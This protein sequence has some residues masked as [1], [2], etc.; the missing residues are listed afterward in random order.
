MD[1]LNNFPYSNVFFMTWPKIKFQTFQDYLWTLWWSLWSHF[2]FLLFESNITYIRK[3]MKYKIQLSLWTN[4][5]HNIT[6]EGKKDRQHMQIHVNATTGI[7]TL[8]NNR[9]LITTVVW[10]TGLL[11]P[12]APWYLSLHLRQHWV[13][14]V[15]LMSTNLFSILKSEDSVHEKEL[16]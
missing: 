10:L 11:N 3:S 14:C 2:L 4:I 15:C 9:L 16:Y 13:S 7:Y 5:V 1:K 12:Q 6:S 8:L